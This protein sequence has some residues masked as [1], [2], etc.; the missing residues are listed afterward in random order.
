MQLDLGIVSSSPMLGIEPTRKEKKKH[1]H[2]ALGAQSKDFVFLDEGI[3]HR[4]PRE[5]G[6]EV[7]D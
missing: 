7:G 3:G 5:A 2:N 6:S 4:L 1:K